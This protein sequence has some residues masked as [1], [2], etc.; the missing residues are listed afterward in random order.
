[1][2]TRSMIVSATLALA[3][4]G[5]VFLPVQ[6]DEPQLNQDRLQQQIRDRAM[7][8]QNLPDNGQQQ[9]RQEQHEYTH[10]NRNETRSGNRQGNRS[11]DMGQGSFGGTGS[12][13]GGGRGGR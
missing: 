10:Q 9:M 4:T 13:G 11:S 8:Q 3:M 2:F 5:G 1:M 6:A 7:T 12:M